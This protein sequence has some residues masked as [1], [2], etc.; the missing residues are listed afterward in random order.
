M[1]QNVIHFHHFVIQIGWNRLSVK[2][3]WSLRNVYH[4]DDFGCQFWPRPNLYCKILE[5]DQILGPYDLKNLTRWKFEFLQKISLRNPSKE[6][7][8][9]L[10]PPPLT[11]NCWYPLWQIRIFLMY[12]Y[13][14]FKVEY[15]PFP[16]YSLRE[17]FNTKK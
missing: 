4:Y 8:G 10:N 16:N 7:L 9:I 14:D 13:V 11:S 6:C 15:S 5:I 3:W 1:G 12:S 17:G 2:A